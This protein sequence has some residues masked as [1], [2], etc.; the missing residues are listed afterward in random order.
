MMDAM[1]DDA[2]PAE[3]MPDKL[4]EGIIS[5]LAEII[6]DEHLWECTRS[7]PCNMTTCAHDRAQAAF[8]YLRDAGLLRKGYFAPPIPVTETALVMD[9]REMADDLRARIAYDQARNVV[10]RDAGLWRSLGWDVGLLGTH[11]RHPS[12]AVA[13]LFNVPIWRPTQDELAWFRDGFAGQRE[14]SS[15]PTIRG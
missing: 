5:K 13:V 10:V 15:R 9:L 6:H 1:R 4:L 8:D 11:L 7:L 14:G 3:I 12:E 2:T